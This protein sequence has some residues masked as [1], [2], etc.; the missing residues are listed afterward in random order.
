MLNRRSFLL[1]GLGGALPF[2]L[3]G[4]RHIT[5]NSPPQ[6]L[7]DAM[8]K[9]QQAPID[10]HA[11]VTRHN[12]RRTQIN[13]HSPLQVGNGNFAFGADITG[14]QTFAAFNTLSQWGWHTDPLPPG[15][16]PAEFQG[17]VWDTHGRAIHYPSPDPQQPAL[18]AWLYS[19]PHRMN[20]GR[21]GL[22]LRKADGSDVAANDLTEC[23]Q[24]LDLW[25]GTLDSRLHVEGQPVQVETCC[26]PDQDIVAVRIHSPLIAV[27]RLSVFLDFPREDGREFADFVGA[28]DG[29]YRHETRIVQRLPQRA[30]IAHSQDATQ[31]HAALG[32]GPEISLHTP[33]TMNASEPLAIIQAKY[34]AADREA[35]VT[36]RL[37]DALRDN[38]LT[39]DVNNQTMGGDPALGLPKTLRVTYIQHG[40]TQRIE[41]G[42]NAAMHLPAGTGRHRYTLT[43]TGETMEL[44]CAFAP[45]PLP[46]ALPSAKAVFA[47]SARH[48]P[49]FWQSGG[50]IDLSKSRDPR[51]I[52]L[53]R[54]VVLSQYLMAVNEAGTLPPQESGLVNTGWHGKFHMEMY[55]WHGAHYALW[56]RWPLLERSLGIYHHFL[57]TARVRAKSEGV[58]GARWPKMTS[59]GGQESAHPINALLIWQQPH[60]MFFA[61]LDYRAHP[62]QVTLERWREVLFDTADFLASFAFWDETMQRYV[63]GPP[64]Y[65]V[66]ENT[67]PKVTQ[68]PTFELSYWRFG[69]RTAQT[70]RKRL[71]LSP[72]PK[73][74]KVLTGLAPLP[75]EDGCYVLYEGI[76]D[77]WTRWN[78]EHPALIGVYGWLPGDGVDVPTIRRTADRVF[79]GWQFDHTW[80]W[81]FPMLAMCAARLGNP[82]QAIDFLLHPAAGFQFDDA[83]YATGGPFPYFP[84]NGGLLYAIALMAAGWDGAPSHHAPGFPEDGQWDVRW[85]GLRPAL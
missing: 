10:R 6:T 82:A 9:S 68:N 27:G 57:P 51:G 19:N 52:E 35:D 62:T 83:G 73:W 12:V 77:M 23:L 69:L 59:A 43:G 38:Q 80:G 67:D 20:L 25:H 58:R 48:W 1:L 11:L 7:L 71:G 3:P 32:W 29:E 16:S 74:E 42:E 37:R 46:A 47:A 34:G 22:S 13:T 81:D 66:S 76:T 64:I 75:V 85:E 17:A 36:A 65:V 14:L 63:L 18:S 44:I 21:I 78:F 61:E 72:D 56:D 8:K 49:A 40:K 2:R 41:V 30:D 45:G 55:W 15:P 39:L 24:Q 5:K 60:P 50:A 28:W 84:A 31:Y 33:H 79:Q 4:Q 26:H 53:E 54:R 70:W